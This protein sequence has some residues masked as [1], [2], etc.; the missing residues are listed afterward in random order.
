[1]RKID[2]ISGSPSLSIFKEGANKT[3]VGGVIF[4][5]FIIIFIL[6]SVF[7]IYEYTTKNAFEF[8]HRL[9]KGVGW[10]NIKEKE[11]ANIVSN[12]ERVFQFSLF[13]DKDVGPS[14]LQSKSFIIMDVKRMMKHKNEN[15]DQTDKFNVLN[16]DNEDFIIKQN[17]PYRAIIGDFDLAVLYKCEKDECKIREDDRIITDSYWLRF[18]Y[19]GYDINH[20]SSGDPIQLLPEDQFWGFDIQFLANTN[21]MFL[22]WSLI[23]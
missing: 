16:L 19:Q 14:T 20:Q 22:N 18:L 6:I 11:K 9:I 1:M 17:E 10:Q 4:L 7:Y 23:E 3:N 21:I 8:D 12:T 2:F 15:F 13:K 5:L